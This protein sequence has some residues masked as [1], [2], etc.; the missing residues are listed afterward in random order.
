[1][2]Y[3]DYYPEFRCVAD[4]CKHNCCIGW[5]IDIDE[6][7]LGYY[8]SVDGELG[9]RLKKNICLDETPHFRLLS[10]DRCPFLNDKN[11][12]DLILQLGEERLCQ[13]CTD[14][15]RFRNFLPDRTEIGVGLCCEEAARLILS[16]KEPVK[17]L[18]EEPTDDEII[19]LRNDVISK[20][21]DRT[22]SI[23]ER[24]D[25]ML[26]LC[27]ATLPKK[28]LHEWAD[29]LEGL[30]RLDES[31]TDLLSLLRNNALD[32]EG[33]SEHM[34]DRQTEYEQFLVY[35]VYR[36]LVNAV[37]EFDLADRAAFVAFGYH[38]VY[39]VGVAMWTK[40]R[41]FSLDDQID[42]VRQFSAELEYSDDNMDALLNAMYISDCTD[43]IKA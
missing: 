2:V 6:D 32:R 38:I 7:T 29:L 8:Q 41:H 39:S 13:I 43:V 35:L 24:I 31:W 5:E 18:N 14:H 40:N 17:L 1:M 11:L 33:F 23:A 22:K 15:P 10:N 16:K 9:K 26:A 37:D 19:L 28:S 42:L 21:Q 12:C 34:F 36:H 30:E 25:N 20:L 27:N 4:R 3:P